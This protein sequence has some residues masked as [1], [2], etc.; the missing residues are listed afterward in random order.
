[1][2]PSIRSHP[3]RVQRIFTKFSN[4][5]FANTPL[6]ADLLPRQTVAAS[7]RWPPKV[8]EALMWGILAIHVPKIKADNPTSWSLQ[9][10]G[11]QVQA[12]PTSASNAS[13]APLRSLVRRKPKGNGRPRAFGKPGNARCGS[14]EDESLPAA[15][16]GC[17]AFCG[18]RKVTAAPTQAAR[19]ALF[20]SGSQSRPGGPC[21]RYPA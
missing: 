21:C 20:R 5:P 10:G 1:M 11:A 19:R 14:A 4:A 16:E 17:I 18:G 3:S 2:P 9:S 7:R 8:S 6:A 13:M 15:S 12:R